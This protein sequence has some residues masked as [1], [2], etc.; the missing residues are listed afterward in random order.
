[1]TSSLDRGELHIASISSYTYGIF[2]QLQVYDTE[3]ELSDM[4]ASNAAIEHGNTAL[5]QV[6]C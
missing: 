1:M 4:V 6:R 5:R 3:A 2:Q